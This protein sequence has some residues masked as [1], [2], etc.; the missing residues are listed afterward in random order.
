MHRGIR[1]GGTA[2][3]RW[4]CG[5]VSSLPSNDIDPLPL[6]LLP[7]TLCDEAVFAPLLQRLAAMPGRRLLPLVATLAGGADIGAVA[8]RLLAEAPPRFALLGF[9]LGGMV[10]LQIAAL[11]PD[12]VLGL[13]LIG[14][15]ARAAPDDQHDERRREAQAGADNL[16]D[17]VRR[18]LWPRYVAADNIAD[19][20]LTA[21]IVGMAARGGADDL[22]RQ[23]EMA[24]SRPDSLARLKEMPMPALVLGGL[25]DVV[26]TPDMQ[27]EMAEAL[28]DAALAL[29]PGAG[30]FVLIEQPGAVAQSVAGWLD[31]IGP[32]GGYLPAAAQA[33]LAAESGEP[34]L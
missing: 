17:H 33:K 7:G 30:H 19:P 3:D 20:D 4:G 13:A 1:F 6:L 21:V 15:N 12:R 25:Q 11:A 29:I 34:P 28:P 10:A 18:T 9:S 5:Q 8:H 23:T 31:R 32:P 2:Q 14:S 24:L 27:R 22:M 16:A 26:C